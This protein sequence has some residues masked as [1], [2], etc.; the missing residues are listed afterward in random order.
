M[1]QHDLFGHFG[2]N[3]STALTPTCSNVAPPGADHDEFACPFAKF[4]DFYILFN[5]GDP[6]T[7]NANEQLPAKVLDPTPNTI[8]TV[9]QAGAD[10]FHAYWMKHLSN[11][12]DGL[13]D[14]GDDTVDFVLYD[15]AKEHPGSATFT[16]R[17]PN[18]D[19][20]TQEKANELLLSIGIDASQFPLPKPFAKYSGLKN[21]AEKSL[22]DEQLRS[23]TEAF[24]TIRGEYE[25]VTCRDSG[26]TIGF[27]VS[28][29]LSLVANKYHG[30]HAVWSDKAESG[31]LITSNFSGSSRLLWYPD[32]PLSYQYWGLLSAKTNDHTVSDLRKMFEGF[33]NHPTITSGG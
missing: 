5:N 29:N 16:A 14:T 8:V 17:N 3:L 9:Q 6:L 10:S 13:R 4:S 7:T 27:G 28:K 23:C 1:T 31:Q 26:V 33:A 30:D 15:V 12:K 20:L 24:T 25:H 18:S 21:F 2:D 19:P 11:G 22:T 32:N